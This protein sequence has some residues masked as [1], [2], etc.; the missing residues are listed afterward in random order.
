[1]IIFFTIDNTKMIKAVAAT[2]AIKRYII[3]LAINNI[4]ISISHQSS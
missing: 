2:R 3:I 4:I 1:M